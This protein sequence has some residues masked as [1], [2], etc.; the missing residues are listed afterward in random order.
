MVTHLV[1][2][3]V[4]H[5]TRPPPLVV[6]V[7]VFQHR[8]AAGNPMTLCFTPLL[9]RLGHQDFDELVLYASSGLSLYKLTILGK[10]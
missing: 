5:G 4:T 3:A 8:V 9:K 7:F 2:E 1:T 10:L 6:V